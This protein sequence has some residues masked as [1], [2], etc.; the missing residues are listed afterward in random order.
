MIG[1]QTVL[2]KRKFFAFVFNFIHGRCPMSTS[3]LDLRHL[4]TLQALSETGNLSRAAQLLNLTQSALSH[5]V[6]AL[7][8]AYGAALF[9]RKSTPVGFT[10]HGQR[11]LR[12]ADAVL[13]LVAEAERDLARL[14]Q[15][16][17]GTLRIAVECHTCFDWLMPAMDAL[18]ERWPEV[19]L[20]I[21]SGFH[22]DPVGLLHQGRADMAI[23]SHGAQPEAGISLLP[24]FG[25]EMVAVLPRGHALL[26]KPWLEAADFAGQALIT[27]PVP[28]D[29]LDLV[30]RVLQPDGITPPRRTTELTVAMLQLVASGRGLA[31]LPLWAV[32]PYLD[33]GYVA[34]ARIGELGLAGEL[35]AATPDALRTR[36]YVAEFVQLMRETSLRSLPGVAL[37]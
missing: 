10:A 21:V 8:E 32:K 24:L 2:F 12:L 31:A 1:I 7:E 23:L 35:F 14:A 30:R 37:L 5:Q 17:S 9:E 15:G 27:Y 22:A 34:S 25:F 36:P 18:R 28:D 3:L 4:R 29:M 6:K 19:E 33:R 11:L 20:D 16:A 13:P 26:A